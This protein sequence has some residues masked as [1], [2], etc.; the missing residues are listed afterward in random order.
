MSFDPATVMP[1]ASAQRVILTA[2]GDDSM[3]G[4]EHL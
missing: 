1:H 4:V 2:L 3:S